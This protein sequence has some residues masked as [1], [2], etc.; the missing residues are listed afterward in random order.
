MNPQYKIEPK[1]P[2]IV[3]VGAGFG[4]LRAAKAFAKEEVHVTIVDRNNYHLF[5]PLLYQVATA[6]LSNNDIAYPL[7]GIFRKQ[8][9]LAFLFA[10]VQKI[11]LK[12]KMI[13]T[14]QGEI[15]YDY[16][17][18]SPGSETNYYGN[19]SI[20]R[21]SFGLKD[22]QDARRIRQHILLQY[23]KASREKDPEIRTA[24]LRFVIA[25]GGPSGVEM[26]GAISELC[27]L[28]LKKDF[29]A[30]NFSE[31]SIV[32]LEATDQLVS[33][34]ETDLSTNTV[35]ALT[36][37]GIEV[38]FGYRVEDFDGNLIHLVPDKKIAARTLIWTAGVRASS[39]LDQLGVEQ[40]N[41]KRVRVLPTLQLPSESSV[42]V[43]GDSA[44]L[45]NQEGKPLPMTAPV[46]IQE[47]NLAARNILAD[48]KH[49]ELTPFKFHNPGMMATIGRNQAVAQIGKLRFKGWIAWLIW[50]FVHLIQIIGFRNRILVL[51]KWFWEYFFYDRAERLLELPDKTD[52]QN[53]I[54]ANQMEQMPTTSPG[55]SQS[56]AGNPNF[57]V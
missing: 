18:L 23:E 5:Q 12:K 47:A 15:N 35:E 48:I 50:L 16:L 55:K 8:S 1:I 29:P 19:D 11:D 10:E 45:E 53:F 27:R 56:P 2:E 26:A 20:A 34:L 57:P 4:G 49:Q 51:F 21:N 46:A 41:Q 43:I 25:G 39:I 33:H 37:K 9:N 6:T 28:V 24:L 54:S 32:L 3:I 17:I 14:N 44:Y 22:L 13:C 42:Y 30:I 7:R 40:V 36:R 38:I 52:N 31:V